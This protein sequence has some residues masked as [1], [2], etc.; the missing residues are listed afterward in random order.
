MLKDCY[1]FILDIQIL[2]FSVSFPHN[3]IITLLL[4]VVFQ[5]LISKI[6]IN[7]SNQKGK[8]QRVEVLLK[9]LVF[10]LLYM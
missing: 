3:M 10:C 8:P 9:A 6:E 5:H 7:N 1:S 2:D 4:L